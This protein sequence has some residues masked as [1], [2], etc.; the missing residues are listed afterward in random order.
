MIELTDEEAL[1]KDEHKILSGDIIIVGLSTDNSIA[2]S[3]NGQLCML[4]I[5]FNNPSITN[6][7]KGP[8]IFDNKVRLNKSTSLSVAKQQIIEKL[9]LGEPDGFHLCLSEKACML[10][11]EKLTLDDSGK[12]CTYTVLF[13][14][15]TLSR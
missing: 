2:E 9:G 12:Y 1:L 10:K 5:Y 8:A 3:L 11:D 14:L 4:D 7:K 6:I 15:S 13:A